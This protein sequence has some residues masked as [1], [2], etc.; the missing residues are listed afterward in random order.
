MS[1]KQCLN[2]YVT[3]SPASLAD[4]AL[5]ARLQEEYL[6][7][8]RVLRESPSD[9]TALQYVIHRT[10]TQ[11]GTA[12][13]ACESGF[14]PMP[15][16]DEQSGVLEGFDLIAP[17]GQDFSKSGTILTIS[18]SEIPLRS[19]EKKQSPQ[20]RDM[21]SAQIQ[22]L[23]D[24]LDGFLHILNA[25]MHKLHTAL[26]II[27]KQTW[28]QLWTSKDAMWLAA[29]EPNI[30]EHLDRLEGLR[31]I[32]VQ[33]IEQA[34]AD[35]YKHVLKGEDPLTAEERLW[36]IHELLNDLEERVSILK[37]DMPL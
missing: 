5:I 17:P 6:E 21:R 19:I 35:I 22:L 36:E 14:E 18:E 25:C 32:C 12:M 16:F 15:V 33:H 31:R 28:W 23:R 1:G 10:R 7:G 9:T 24:N 29:N 13:L 2:R 27:S 26:D 11:F 30:Q 37:R 20:E 8:L 4:E 34:V 3:L